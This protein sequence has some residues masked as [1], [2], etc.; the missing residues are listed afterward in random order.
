MAREI[1][2][3]SC[4]SNMKMFFTAFGMHNPCA[5]KLFQEHCALP[6]GIDAKD[7]LDLDYSAILLSEK[8]IIDKSAREY[9]RDRRHRFLKPMDHSLHVLAE[10]GFLEEADFSLLC[11]GFEE[12]TENKA[13]ELLKNVQ[14]WLV[15]AR[16]Q[17]SKLQPELI[18]FQTRYGQA[19]QASINI[20]HFGILNYLSSK[21]GR[22]PPDESSRLH[23]LFETGRRLTRPEET[24]VQ[25]ILKPLVAQILVNDLV[26]KKLNAPLIDWDDAQ[27]FYQRLH[28]G[29][30]TELEESGFPSI[31]A[32]GQARCLF[33]IVVPE[34]L[35]QR[36]EDVVKFLRNRK[37][38]KSLRHD[39]FDSLKHG[40]GVSKEWMI[41]L[42]DEAAKAQLRAEKRGRI[43]KWVGRI[44]SIAVPGGE[45]LGGVVLEGTKK[46]LGTLGE[47]A[48]D[49]A[50]EVA[51]SYIEQSGKNKL[52]WYYA[53][54]NLKLDA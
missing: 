30:W 31:G 35:P 13:V 14:P 40:Q 42:M 38:V 2:K 34:L 22:I 43:V 51:G 26:R 20:A 45:A 27:G 46:L 3:E 25:E 10:E 33:S 36:I 23:N 16:Q 12:A 53:L 47:F 54:Q 7:G 37:A 1:V 39:L 44:A 41:K 48:L 19:R 17:W 15:V 32:A 21:H 29:Q 50:S 49:G 6:I 5:E 28:L 18:E 4:I 9:V 11:N 8:F 24:E 52:E